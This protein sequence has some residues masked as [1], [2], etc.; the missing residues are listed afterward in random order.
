MKEYTTNTRI[1]C[2]GFL[3][4]LFYETTQFTGLWFLYPQ[5]YRYATVDDLICK[6]QKPSKQPK[7]LQIRSS[8]VA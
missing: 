5:A 3:V 1:T 7:V 4:S 2:I 6:S 8:T